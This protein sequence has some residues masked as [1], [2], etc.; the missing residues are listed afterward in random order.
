MAKEYSWEIRERA[1]ELYIIDGLIYEDVATETGV[2]VSQLK[3]WGQAS[4]WRER[5]REYRQAQ[6]SIRHSVMLAKEKLIKSVIDTEDTQKAYAFSSLVTSSAA[7]E[8]AA[9][10]H[11]APTAGPTRIIKTTQDAVE[12]LQEAVAKKINTMLS[13]PGALSFAAIKDTKQAMEMVEQLRA[14]YK[15]EDE[16]G[17]AEGL[18]D[19]TA[20]EIRKEI[21]GL[22]K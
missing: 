9:G 12:A 16:T 14:K 10:E 6:T 11:R 13:E 5:R 22:S 4:G 17:K 3:R 1:E 15:P 19:D 2:S 7:I 20:E 18:S 8:K 21:F